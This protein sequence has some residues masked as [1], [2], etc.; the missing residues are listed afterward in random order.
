MNGKMLRL[1]G[2]RNVYELLELFSIFV[3][4]YLFALL[5]G[6]ENYFQIKIEIK[7]DFFFLVINDIDDK[8]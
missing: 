3:S 1:R 2:A 6:L 5:R 4:N 7:I 8:I